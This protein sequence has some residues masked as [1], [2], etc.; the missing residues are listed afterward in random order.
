MLYSR[1][2]RFPSSWLA[3]A[4][5]A[6]AD[7]GQDRGAILRISLLAAGSFLLFLLVG[8]RIYFRAFVRAREDSA[9][10]AIGAGLLTRGLD[11]L[12]SGLAPPVRALLRKEVRILTRDAARFTLK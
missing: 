3:A 12:T 2:D 11:R 8:Q 4:A 6:R 10:V 9:P 1:T 7:R 5:A